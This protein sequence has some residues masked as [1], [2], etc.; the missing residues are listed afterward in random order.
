MSTVALPKKYPTGIINKKK[1][2]H[3]I[4]L[5]KYVPPA[6]GTFYKELFVAQEGVKE[7]EVGENNVDD[8]SDDILDY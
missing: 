6:L 1:L 4:F 8:P 5:S 2:Q 3:I 7:P